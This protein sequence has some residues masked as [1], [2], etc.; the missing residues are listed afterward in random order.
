MDQSIKNQTTTPPQPGRHHRGPLPVVLGANV[1]P[2]APEQSQVAAKLGPTDAHLELTLKLSS[3]D[4][5]FAEERCSTDL[6]DAL[7]ARNRG[8]LSQ[9][10]ARALELTVDNAKI[11]TNMAFR[12]PQFPPGWTM[13]PDASGDDEAAGICSP[14]ALDEY[15][16]IAPPPAEK[17]TPVPKQATPE[18][19]KE[20][21][22]PP[23][24]IPDVLPSPPQEPSGPPAKP[25]A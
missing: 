9:A 4:S 23:T 19:M 15:P 22:K 7:S 1:P 17:V 20:P 10:I 11:K 2:Q 14:N 18:P 25:L 12:E 21:P 6:P 3:R 8:A 13:R 5:V 24:E 16:L